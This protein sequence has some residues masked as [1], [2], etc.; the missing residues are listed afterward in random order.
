MAGFSIDSIF[1]NLTNTHTLL[2]RSH[3]LCLHLHGLN[4]NKTWKHSCQM[5]KTYEPLPTDTDTPINAAIMKYV[6]ISN[7]II[8]MDYINNKSW[9]VATIRTSP[10]FAGS[11]QRR[12]RNSLKQ[13]MSLKSQK[14]SLHS[15]REHTWYFSDP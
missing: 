9:K 4:C 2:L 7:N 1:G 6:S 5:Q 10:L 12:Q 15:L 13:G 8:A 14:Y 3:S 11:T